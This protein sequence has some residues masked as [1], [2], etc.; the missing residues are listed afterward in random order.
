MIVEARTPTRIDLSGG[1]LD[2]HPLYLFLDGGVTNNA[3]IDLWS[4]VRIETR[5]DTEIHLK[6]I[7]TA[8]ELAVGSLAELPVDTELSL[9]ARVVKLYAPQTG[10]NVTTNNLSPLGSGLGGSSSLIVALSGAL[11][12]INGTNLQPAQFVDFGSNLGAQVIA[13]PTG[14][15]DYL[16]AVYG[17]VN[18][19]HFGARG[20][21]REQL[22]ADEERLG[23]FEGRIV[24]TFTG[25]SR[26][27]GTNNWNM[28][29]RFID[30]VG[31]CRASMATIQRTAAEMREALLAYDLDRFASLLDREWQSRKQLAEGVTTPTIERM[32]EA[33]K[34]AG[35]LASKICGAGGGGCMITFVQKGKR[36]AVEAALESAGAT[37]L[38]F[39]IARQG[40]TVETLQ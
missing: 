10:V 3:A 40:L 14:K 9:L 28:M 38:A 7:D 16:A 33:A 32:V 5:E 26:F 12:C 31:N 21:S 34:S 37:V 15:Q 23:E 20:W 18:A 24:L 8:A 30:D 35:G 17:G 29:K 2:L 36:E 39:R 6:S 19:F 13:M 4:T 11:D 25:E 27:S 22:I 1:T